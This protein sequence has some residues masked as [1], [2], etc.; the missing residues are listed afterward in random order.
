MLANAH[1]P[2]P[3]VC[4]FIDLNDARC[5]RHFTLSHLG[6][7]FELCLRRHANCVTFYRILGERRADDD[8]APLPNVR[9]TVR[10]RIPE[11]AASRRQTATAISGRQSTSDADTRSNPANTRQHTTKQNEDPANTLQHTTNHHQPPPNTGQQPNDTTR[12][13]NHNA[14]T[15]HDGDCE[16]I[17]FSDTGLRKTGS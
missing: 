10:G 7:A 8:P 11:T 14:T 9:L 12:A 13:A 17:P 3:A 1:Q 5:A 2:E 4:P 16:P 6:E 15:N